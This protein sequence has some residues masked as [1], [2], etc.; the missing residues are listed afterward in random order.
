[1]KNSC[2]CLLLLAFILIAKF[3]RSQSC[4][5]LG[6]ASTYG[7][8]TANTN[9]VGETG[10]GSCY[11]NVIYKQ[12]YWE[13]FYSPNGGNFE[14]IFTPVNTGG[15]PLDIDYSVYDMGITGPGG[16]NCPVNVSGFTEVICQLAPTHG[17]PTGPGLDGAVPTLAGHYYAVIIYVYQDDDPFYT[18]TTGT[19]SINGVPFDALN[20]PGVLP[21]QLKSF[22]AK[23]NGCNVQLSWAVDA[24]Q[25]LDRY[26]IQYSSNGQQFSSVGIK[27]SAAVSGQHI[28]QFEHSPSSKQ[29]FYR[30]KMTDHDGK[31]RYSAVVKANLT[32]TTSDY[33]IYPNP[34]ADKLT[35]TLN[36][37]TQKQISYILFDAR[38]TRI[39]TGAISG[40][41]NTIDFRDLP[42]GIYLL[43]IQSEGKTEQFRLVH[44]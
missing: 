38:G 33:T 41:G 18:F 17:N 43:K 21:V 42:P 6:C 9:V 37:L 27:K 13:F 14:Q 5:I 7:P 40:M 31:Y 1:M 36:A 32:C 4:N 25:D 11:F 24:E 35:V 2:K 44:P 15:D 20:C 3:S 26:E 8:I 22:T 16:I 23:S 29:C 34:V 39:K 12:A 19:P 10:F 30:L 28:Y